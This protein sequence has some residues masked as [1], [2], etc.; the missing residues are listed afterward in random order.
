MTLVCYGSK[1]I[2]HSAMVKHLLEAVLLPFELAIVKC[3]AHPGASDSVS[4]S[5]A[6]ADLAAKQA[7]LEPSMVFLQGPKPV[8]SDLLPVPPLDDVTKLQNSADGSEKAVWSKKGCTPSESGLWLH[9]DGRIVAPWS[10]LHA[11]CQLAHG[12]S[13]VGGDEPCHSSTMVRTRDHCCN[14]TL[15]Q[16]MFVLNMQ[17]VRSHFQNMIT[18]DDCEITQASKEHASSDPI[19]KMVAV[20]CHQ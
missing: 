3:K 7:A 20:H 5:N 15:L 4:R 9:P 19:P 1:P 17:Q 6:L 13:H 12:P 16:G 11:L 2:Q 14:R 8:Q 18:C 10:L